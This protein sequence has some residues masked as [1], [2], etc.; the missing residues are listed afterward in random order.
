[1]AI[2]ESSF[3]RRSIMRT[4]FVSALALGAMTSAALAAD[5]ITP[6]SDRTGPVE[7]TSAQMNQV[8]AGQNV[9]VCVV[10]ANA[11]IAA[12]LNLLAVGSAAVATTGQQTINVGSGGGG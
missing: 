1:L 8:V 3:D 5:P 7:L 12:A 10:C 2:L 9:G 6:T 4:F 11:G